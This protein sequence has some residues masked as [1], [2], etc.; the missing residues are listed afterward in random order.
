MNDKSMSLFIGRQN[1]RD[2]TPITSDGAWAFGIPDADMK[3]VS[4]NSNEARLYFTGDLISI[5]VCGPPKIY[6]EELTNPRS[7]NF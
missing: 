7:D 2:L 4:H 5:E 3:C 1:R 6:R